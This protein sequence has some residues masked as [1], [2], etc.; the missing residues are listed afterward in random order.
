[1]LILTRSG[2]DTLNKE[3]EIAP[4]SDVVLA[5]AAV[6]SYEPHFNGFPAVSGAAIVAIKV[7]I[8]STIK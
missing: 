5:R 8:A 2:V 7:R 1:M 4:G 3:S 6:R